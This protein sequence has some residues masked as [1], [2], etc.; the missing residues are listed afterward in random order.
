[1]FRKLL[2]SAAI[3]GLTLSC[4]CVGVIG[5]TVT[6]RD[7]LMARKPV[8]V[9]GRIYIVDV[10]TGRVMAMDPGACATAGPFEPVIIKEEE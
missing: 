6:V 3:L 7:D 2:G 10:R 8:V 1:M 5:N 4:G 9:D